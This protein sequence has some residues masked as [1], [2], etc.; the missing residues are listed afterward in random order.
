MLHIL[1]DAAAAAAAANRSGFMSFGLQQRFGS[2]KH[3]PVTSAWLLY[4][5]DVRVCVCGTDA[6]AASVPLVFGCFLVQQSGACKKSQAPL[7][8]GCVS[9][10]SNCA[11]GVS[12]LTFTS[13]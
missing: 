1:A 10:G 8:R 7:G 11:V 4:I 5:F 6:A 3:A 9:C 12:A 13:Q 2:C